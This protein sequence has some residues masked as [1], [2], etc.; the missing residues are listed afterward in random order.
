LLIKGKYEKLT[1]NPTLGPAAEMPT[2]VE[3]YLEVAP[4]KSTRA[5]FLLNWMDLPPRVPVRSA[6]GASINP[7]L[8]SKSMP[9][10][11]AFWIDAKCELSASV[12]GRIW[13][14]RLIRNQFPDD[15]VTHGRNGCR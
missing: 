3:T 12:A 5:V 13:T 7:K 10:I 14:T 8:S 15:A 11:V 2:H 6:A 1:E 9:A 4:P